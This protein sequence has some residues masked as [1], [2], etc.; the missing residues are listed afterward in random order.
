MILSKHFQTVLES[1]KPVKVKEPETQKID[2]LNKDDTEE[3]TYSID[4]SGPAPKVDNTVKVVKKGAAIPKEK[5]EKCCEGVIGHF[6]R[7]LTLAR[8]AGLDHKLSSIQK[9]IDEMH[10]MRCKYR[11]EEEIR[12]QAPENVPATNDAGIDPAGAPDPEMNDTSMAVDAE[13][14]Q[15]L[16]DEQAQ[17]D[18]DIGQ[19]ISDVI[20]K[21]RDNPE[22][23][24][25]DAFAAVLAQFSSDMSGD[26]ADDVELSIGGDPD[27]G[28]DQDTA[29]GPEGDTAVSLE[30]RM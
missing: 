17:P 19:V 22:M 2:Q 29:M 15:G 5:F 13:P 11:E 3:V 28:M 18:I 4:T 9:R 14:M 8:L 25:V 23:R 10:G 21:M 6:E 1:L 24:A 30:P 27:A 12:F 26:N 20:N 7:Q 16:P